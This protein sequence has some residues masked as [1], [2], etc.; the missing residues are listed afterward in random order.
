MVVFTAEAKVCVRGHFMRLLLVVFV[1]FCVCVEGGGR[2][3]CL[4]LS[5]LFLTYSTN[6]SYYRIHANNNC[7]TV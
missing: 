3:V 5:F 1:F 7:S 4:F 2:G 6:A